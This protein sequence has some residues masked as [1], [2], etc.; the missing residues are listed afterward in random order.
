M[1]LI[2]QNIPSFYNQEIYGAFNERRSRY[3]GQREQSYLDTIKDH[4]T[5]FILTGVAALLLGGAG[6]FVSKNKHYQATFDKIQENLKKIGGKSL[7]GTEKVKKM[8]YQVAMAFYN[9][10]IYTN[11][12]QLK[13]AQKCG[14]L[15][16]KVIDLSQASRKGPRKLAKVNY[17]NLSQKAGK[18]SE[19]IA[20]FELKDL[21]SAEQKLV[22]EL[23]QFMNE[24][25]LVK[26]IEKLRDSFASRSDTMRKIIDKDDVQ[27]HIKK[28]YPNDWSKKEFLRHINENWKEF[29]SKEILRENW[30]NTTKKLFENIE[31]TGDGKNNVGQKIKEL[32]EIL[33][34]ID[35]VKNPSKSLNNLKNQI[36]SFIKNYDDAIKFEVNRYGGRE[37]DLLAGGGLSEIVLPPILGV[38]LARELTKKTDPN[39]KKQ[40][41]FDKFVEKS[42]VAFVGGLLVWGIVSGIFGINGT[43]AYIL[44]LGSGFTLDKGFK[45]IYKRTRKKE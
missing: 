7:K 40:P 39:E 20:N 13:L 22:E 34:K 31:N 32:R 21:T 1:T 37:L 16:Q 33:E 35:K 41:F 45:E 6:L 25:E 36:N 42:G 12:W 19:K 15:G 8:F 24:K 43:P 44:G 23:K 9:Q 29:F 38:I 11:V 2:M 14:W 26:L 3:S 28:Y 27:P 30:G 4:K 10:N 18:L 17:V 5:G